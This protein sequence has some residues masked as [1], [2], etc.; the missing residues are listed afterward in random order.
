MSVSPD[1]IVAPATPAGTSALAVLRAS[2]PTVTAIAQEVL[3][4]DLVPRTVH[5][6]KY[7]AKAG[8]FVDE[9]LV[10]LFPTP[11]S[12]TGE[13]VLE[14]SC[15]GNPFIVRKLLEDLMDRGC[16]AA[17]PGE[18]TRRAF[19]NGKMDL[20]QAE[21]V[22]DLIHAKSERALVSAHQ[23]L[24]GVLGRRLRELCDWLVM[25]LAR[26][27]AYIDFPE[28]DLPMEDRTLAE[29]QLNHILGE[30]NRLMA[31]NRYGALLREGLRVIIIG[32]PNVGKSTLLN[33]LAA[34]DRA[35][36]SPIPG[37]TR[38]YLEETISIGPHR[39]RLV[40]TAGLST[41]T[42]EIEKCGIEKTYEQSSIADLFLW[43]QDA[44]RGFVP[45]PERIA[46]LVT[47]ENTLFVFNKSDKHSAPVDLPVSFSAFPV[48]YIS[49]LAGQGIELLINAI[50][51]FADNFSDQTGEELIAIN[52]RHTKALSRAEESLKSAKV[53]L[54]NNL[55]PELIT[56]DL[57]VAL[58]ALGEING[59]IDNEA[60]LDSLFASFCIGK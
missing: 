43:V 14:I 36:V 5:L 8:E 17:D 42:N 49:A 16:R 53:Q 15:H 28:E 18:F 34:R 55:F 9:V 60:I 41:Q 54:E 19:L 6:A 57:K 35:L 47:A 48:L 56:H 11:R 52:S 21:A 3:G 33:R 26:I 32:E 45:L 20:S 46:R 31:T 4:R 1:T 40:D 10:T 27:E 22:I 23:Q 24:R 39:I 50:V 58:A 44:S 30:L 38:D 29:T 59:K 13:D 12:Y 25:L 2:G 7:C 51:S 37:T